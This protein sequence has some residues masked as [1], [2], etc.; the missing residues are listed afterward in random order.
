MASKMN[1]LFICKYN[2][3]RS[4]VAEAYFKKI[5]KDK[6]IKVKSAGL[7]KGNPLDKNQIELA[8]KFKLDIKGEPRGLS[9]KLLK[10]QDL[11]ILVANDVPQEVFDKKYTKKLI[12]WKI[13]DNL[14]TEEATINEIIKPLIKKVDGLNKTLNKE[15]K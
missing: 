15:A 12:V 11:V 8:K 3:F 6:K 4:R 1:I 10:E 2:R 13:P 7:I 9:S 14:K 5:N